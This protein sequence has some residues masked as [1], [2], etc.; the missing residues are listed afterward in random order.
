MSENPNYVGLSPWMAQWWVDHLDTKPAVVI[1]CGYCEPGKPECRN[2]IGEV[3]AD[4]DVV[5]ASN[6]N[7][8]PEIATDWAPLGAPTVEEL[9]AELAEREAQVLRYTGNGPGAGGIVYRRTA[10]PREVAPVNALGYYTCRHHG[11]I[12]VN[13]AD[14]AA[15]VAAAIRDTPTATQTY[16]AHRV[17]D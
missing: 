2:A 5:L 17:I 16:R 13:T 12:P 8:H 15:F 9:A 1:R 6:R 10:L 7:E 4:G 3:K 11:E 14:L